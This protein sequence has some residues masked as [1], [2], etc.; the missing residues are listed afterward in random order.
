MQVFDLARRHHIGQ[1][2]RRSSTSGDGAQQQHQGV[3]RR[4][5]SG[6]LTPKGEGL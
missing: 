3:V 1:G 2:R 5:S 6:L 4:Q